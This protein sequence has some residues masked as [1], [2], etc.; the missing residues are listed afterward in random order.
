MPVQY[1]YLSRLLL[2]IS[3]FRNVV[4]CFAVG[5]LVVLPIWLVALHKGLLVDLR[6]SSLVQRGVT[7]ALAVGRSLCACVEV[8]IQFTAFLLLCYCN[9]HNLSVSSLKGPIAYIEFGIFLVNQV[10]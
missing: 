4:G 9:H 6:I 10:F 7:L 1:R 3:D 8:C 2:C 5:S